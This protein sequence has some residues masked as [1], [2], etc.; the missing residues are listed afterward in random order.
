M[1]DLGFTNLLNYALVHLCKCK[2]IFMGMELNLMC[3]S[4]LYVMGMFSYETNS[5][6]LLA[7]IL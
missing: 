5:R 2:L 1:I 4:K 6:N 7:T 3:V